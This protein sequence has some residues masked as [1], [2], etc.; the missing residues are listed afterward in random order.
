MTI[1]LLLISTVRA[2]SN[3]LPN[4]HLPLRA[5]LR[6]QA[7]SIPLGVCWPA[8]TATFR[9]SWPA[10]LLACRDWV[11]LDSAGCPLACATAGL[12]LMRR[13]CSFD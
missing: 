12:P 2:E 8:A 13:D 5:E 3:A 10:R 4:S 6:G 1:D 9:P 11:N 7:G